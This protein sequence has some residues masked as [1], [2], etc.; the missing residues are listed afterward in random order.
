M[1]RNPSWS[2]DED[3]KL[4]A[5]GDVPPRMSRVRWQAIADQ[6][7]NNRTWMACR[8]RYLD[9]RRENGM[10]R[11]QRQFA[12]MQEPL[13]PHQMPRHASPIAAMLGDPPL[14]RSALDQRPPAP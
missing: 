9:L 4:P 5:V 10:Q 7:G 2:P 13:A 8:Q 12:E 6:V 1:T 11:R 14:G 3:A